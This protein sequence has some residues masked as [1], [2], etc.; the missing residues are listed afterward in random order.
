V[1]R[2]ALWALTGAVTAVALFYVQYIPELLPGW[3]EPTETS[4]A[5]GDLIELTVTPLAAL[6]MA[7]HRINI[8]Y[9]PFFGLL[10][11]VGLFFVRKH[12]AHRLALPLVVGTL[13]SFCGLNFLRSGLGDTHIFQFTKDALVLLP[14]AS[15]V[16]GLTVERLRE[17]GRIGKAAAAA[18]LAGWVA[19]GCLAL[20][21]DVQIRFVRPDYPPVKNSVGYDYDRAIP[22]SR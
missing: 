21:R 9:G 10:I 19:W 4:V 14:L 5:T 1:T 2:T 18:V 20:V 7:A 16:F 22:V 3:L 6:K 13:V 15:I 8:F 17:R 12:V 11:F